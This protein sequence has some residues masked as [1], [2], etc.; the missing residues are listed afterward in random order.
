MITDESSGHAKR[1]DRGFCDRG[2][3]WQP[4]LSQRWMGQRIRRNQNYVEATKVA[5]L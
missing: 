5:P 4:T 3:P 2:Q 1:F